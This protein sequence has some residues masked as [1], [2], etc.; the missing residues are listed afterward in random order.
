MF[1]KTKEIYSVNIKFIQTSNNKLLI[2]TNQF[3]I[4]KL[5]NSAEKIQCL[6]YLASMVL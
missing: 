1:L 6:G 3:Y 2:I 5:K 4:F